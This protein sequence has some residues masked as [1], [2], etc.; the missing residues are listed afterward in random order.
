MNFVETKIFTLLSDFRA[1]R[2]SAGSVET[3]RGR[4][5]HP[6]DAKQMSGVAALVP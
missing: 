6:F 1:F 5:A 3:T 2:V 4:D